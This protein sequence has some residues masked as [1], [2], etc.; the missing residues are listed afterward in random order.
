M[1][2]TYKVVIFI[3]PFLV[4]KQKVIDLSDVQGIS[5]DKIHMTNSCTNI[6]VVFCYA[7]MDMLCI[8]TTF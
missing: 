1:W 4:Y 7:N 8:K 6:M 5:E 2:N 3:C